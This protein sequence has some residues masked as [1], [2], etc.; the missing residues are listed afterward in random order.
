MKN[1][2]TLIKELGLVVGGTMLSPLVGKAASGVFSTSY[3]KTTSAAKTAILIGAG[4]RGNRFGKYAF[5]NPHQLR[6]V[7][8]ADAD[9]SR[10]EAF[11]NQH[12]IAKTN[13]NTDA[14]DLLKMP[15]FADLVIFTEKID[16]PKVL[17]AAVKAGYE[18]WLDNSA[19]LKEETFES[20]QTGTIKI[21]HV[22]PKQILNLQV[23]DRSHFQSQVLF[24]PQLNPTETSCFLVMS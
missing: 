14:I 7:G 8:I 20:V 15:K 10:C 18:V 3:L 21:V 23:K 24:S 1:R 4:I 17:Y 5:N 22:V 6:M 2:R 11:V 9:H 13:C 19:C 16:D 12:S